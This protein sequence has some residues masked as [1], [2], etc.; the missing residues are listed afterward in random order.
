MADLY[1]SSAEL[2]PKLVSELTGN[3][4]IPDYQRG[5]RW[6]R[7]QVRQ[8]IEDISEAGD[9]TYYLQ[10]IVTCKYKGEG[11]DYDIVDGQQ[12][13][14]TILIVFKALQSSFS[15][16]N[17]RAFEDVKGNYSI[18][19]ETRL[20]SKDFLNEIDKKSIQEAGIFADYLYMYHAYQEALSWFT[21]NP[22]NA[23]S[24]AD[25]LNLNSP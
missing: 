1:D 5:Y 2:I 4:F 15:S 14:T 25:A 18:A 12:R 9:G 17:F 11:Y 16:F 21:S 20:G 3:Y 10:P 13:L 7:K 23:F 6:T 19:Y 22:K 8:L 24:V